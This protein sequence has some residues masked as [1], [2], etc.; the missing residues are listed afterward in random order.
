MAE[1]ATITTR[2]IITGR[3]AE[4]LNNLSVQRI[5]KKEGYSIKRSPAK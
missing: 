3:L 2:I 4:P 5:A 1:I